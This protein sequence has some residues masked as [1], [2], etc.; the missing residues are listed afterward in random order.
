M[1][2]FSRVVW[3][4]RNYNRNETTIETQLQSFRI[5]DRHTGWSPHSLTKGR[6]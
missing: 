2:M 3:T 6:R 1:P 5:Y 4:N